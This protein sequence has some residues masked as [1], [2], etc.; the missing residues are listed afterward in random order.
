MHR[1]ITLVALGGLLSACATASNEVQPSYVS[2][3]QYQHYTCEQLG[4]EAQAISARAS[5]L[6]GIQDSNRTSDAVWTTVA[7]VVAW[8]A[9]F[10]LEGDNETTAELARMK[11]ELEAIRKTSNE[12]NCGIQFQEVTAPPP[13]PKEARAANETVR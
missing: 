12:K 1:K 10:A 8:P 6:A 9:V 3:M 7:I 11:G 2:A 5:Q 13:A 4:R